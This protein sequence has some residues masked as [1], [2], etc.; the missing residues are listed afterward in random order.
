MG[1]KLRA[2]QLIGV[3]PG[4]PPDRYA[5]RD[6]VVN[7]ALAVRAG[8]PE[9]ERRPR[10]YENLGNRELPVYQ[11]KPQIQRMIRDNQISMIEGPTGSGKSTQVGQYAL[12]MG[13]RKIIYLVPRIPLA[14]NLADRIEQEL[15]WQLGADAAT[16]LI[17]VRHADRSTGYKKTIEVMTPDTFLRVF[18]ELAD[19]DDE[20]VL[21]LGDEIHEKDFPTEL[22]VAVTAQVLEQ[23]PK[24]RLS[25]MSATL[26]EQSI[27]AAYSEASGSEVPCVSIEGR[28]FNLEII[29]RPDLTVTEAYTDYGREVQ[30]QK[31]QIFLPGK[32]EIRDTTDT[33]ESMGL[34]KTRITPF[35]AKLPRRDLLQATHANLRPDEKQIIPSTKA[36]QSGITIPGLT[37]VISDGTT[38]RPDI[39]VDGVEGLFR[40]YCT[41]D[42]I[43]QQ[44]GRAGRDVPGGVLVLAK[45]DDDLF[46]FKPIEAR[47]EHAPAQ[48]YH[49]NIA[50]NA[51]AVSCLEHNFSEL[52]RKWL[53]S[54]VS[55]RRVLEAYEV[56]Y[57]LGAIDEL[58][59]AT[60]LGH[61]MNKFPLRPELSRALTAAMEA[62]ADAETLRQLVAMTSAVEAGGLPYFDKDIGQA[63]RDDIRAETEDDYTAQLDM[64][65]ATRQ[66]YD[67]KDVDEVAL[68]A[69]NYD[70]RNT[71][72]AHRTYDK[73][74]RVLHLATHTDVEV[75]DSNKTD[76]LRRYLTAGL[77]DYTY[78]RHAPDDQSRK[79]T[80]LNVNDTDQSKRRDLTDRGT[81]RG[82]DPLVIGWPRRFEKRVKGELQEFSVIENVFPTTVA[83]LAG[84]ALWLANH[85]PLP[86][87]IVE[88]RIVLRDTLL[89]GSLPIGEAPSRARLTHTA[90]TKRAL[91]EAVFAKKTQ[92][93]EELTSIKR[94]LEWLVRRIPNDELERYFPHGIMTSDWLTEIINQSI[95]ANIDSVYELDNALRSKVV[96]DQI[97][98]ETWISDAAV[99][100]IRERSPEIVQMSGQSYALHYTNGMPVVNGFNLRDAEA[101]PE[102]WELEDGR[103][104][105]INYEIGRN[106]R[107]YSAGEISRYAYSLEA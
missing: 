76:E 48:I 47:E 46:D 102:H 104:I 32:Q 95:T 52:N 39:D 22:A 92:T 86:P 83:N 107:K 17:G 62:G 88:G 31:T 11:K 90:E 15:G 61:A 25:L 103:E 10:M 53:I 18:G 7:R 106:T 4:S 82:D 33:L 54:K 24:W 64:F 59:Q 40:Q 43:I 80:F 34:P 50:R 84:A 49:T 65:R 14:D 96:R 13:Y 105:F 99:Q 71:R 19:Y 45:P 89:H 73:I 3:F 27:Q 72:R 97:G 8:L 94:E 28:P 101:L 12:E 6:R 26:D 63:W 38:R 93:I 51:L 55:N 58:N 44:G 75:P 5:E 91:R 68:E 85:Q 30:H 56:L 35:H 21:V 100:E 36:G 41:Q 37:L 79:P 29:E 57:R 60:K 69:R 81:Y 77:F 20:P 42:E 9:P 87:K 2:D 70:L 23:H 66:F 98:R 74:C 78:Q 67:G 1:R 16:D